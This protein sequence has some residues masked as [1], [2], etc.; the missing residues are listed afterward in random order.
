MYQ[1]IYDSFLTDSKYS[2]TLAIIENRLADLGLSGRIDRLSLFKDA[3]DFVREGVKK[4]VKTIVV[5]G[6]D[7]T[8][9]QVIGAADEV[10]ITFGV[11]PVGSKNEIAGILG[12]EDEMS[13]CDCLSNRLVKKIDLGKINSTYF[14]S[15]IEAPPAE[16]IL[17]CE[18]KFLVNSKK[19]QRVEIYNL[20]ISGEKSDPQDGYLD[21]HLKPGRESF[22][23]S[24]T[25]VNVGFLTRNSE[26]NQESVLPIKKMFLESKNDLT[27]LVDG[28]KN[29]NAPAE[30][31]VLPERLKIIVGKNRL[32]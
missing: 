9:S 1:Y 14:I 21:V 5:V 26:Q 6:N 18:G 31:Q 27:I 15:K 19:I 17:K 2:K 11:I 25:N 4:G 12:I 20:P 30:I 24:A 28:A 23:K 29:I 22:F 32:F 3:R 7:F 10:D 8:L 16:I 13:A